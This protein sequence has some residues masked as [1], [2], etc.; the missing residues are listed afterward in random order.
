MRKLHFIQ[1]QIISYLDKVIEK[2]DYGGTGLDSNSI[3]PS[4]ILKLNFGYFN[5][6]RGILFVVETGG[7]SKST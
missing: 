3:S 5:E 6:T 2:Y 7:E 1:E 4:N